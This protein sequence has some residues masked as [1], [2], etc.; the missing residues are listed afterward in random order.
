VRW[1][2]ASKESTVAVGA[3]RG[4]GYRRKNGEERRGLMAFMRAFLGWM[5]GDNG[6]DWM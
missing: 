1:L 4:A 6:D 3:H 2:T 5:C